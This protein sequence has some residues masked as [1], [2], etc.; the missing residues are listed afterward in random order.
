MATRYGTNATYRDVNVPAVKIPPGEVA[1][2]MRIAYDEYNL[3]TLGVVLGATDTILM[4][5]IPAGARV[6]DVVLACDDLGTTGTCNVGWAASS[7]AVEAAS[8]NGFLTSVDLNT[9]A[10]VFTMQTKEAN[11]SGQFKKFSSEVQLQVN[12]ATATTAT[13]GKIKIAVYYVLD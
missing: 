1:G 7:D 2:R 3:A 13:T 11:V 9:A 10:D 5:K 8:T 6:L 12:M 4:Q